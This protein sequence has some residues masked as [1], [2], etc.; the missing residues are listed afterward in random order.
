[1]KNS[2]TG[3]KASRSNSALQFAQTLAAL[4]ERRNRN[5]LRRYDSYLKQKEFHA[6]GVRHRER[7]FMA[8]NQL[9][10][11]VGAAKNDPAVK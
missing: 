8:G 6:A 10:F 1:M 11:N 9:G 3:R 5:K 2:S 7:L 4:D